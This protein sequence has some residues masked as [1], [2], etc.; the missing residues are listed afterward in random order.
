M[1]LNPF[2][3]LVR[4]QLATLGLAQ[5]P[6]PAIEL[7]EAAMLREAAKVVGKK[8][9]AKCVSKAIFRALSTQKHASFSTQNV[10]QKS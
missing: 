8:V 9:N 3:S 4:N 6:T 5:I 2:S 7:I 10:E 1:K